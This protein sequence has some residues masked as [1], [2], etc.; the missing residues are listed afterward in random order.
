VDVEVVNVQ[1]DVEN[2]DMPCGDRDRFG[3]LG[4][5]GPGD[6]GQSDR[7]DHGTEPRAIVHSKPSVL[8]LGHTSTT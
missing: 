4:N 7:P 8:V 1:L 5:T 3:G 2:V 6:E